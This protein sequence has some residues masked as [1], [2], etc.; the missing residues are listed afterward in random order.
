MCYTKSRLTYGIIMKI[1]YFICSQVSKHSNP[2]V[3]ETGQNRLVRNYLGKH[4]NS[5]GIDSATNRIPPKQ[6]IP[7]PIIY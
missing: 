6:S 2:I 4:R 5:K 1:W 3:S 7:K